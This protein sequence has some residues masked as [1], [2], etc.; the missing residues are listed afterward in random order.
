MPTIS[1]IPIRLSLDDIRCAWGA[2]RVRVLSLPLANSLQQLLRQIEAN[3]WLDAAINY[4]VLEVTGSGPGRLEA[5]GAV[6]DSALLAR[7]L[8]QA[9][10]LVFGVCTLGEG[11]LRHMREFFD[12]K[13]PSQAVLLDEIGTLLLY[14]LGDHFEEMM[15]QQ[16]KT[17]GLQA[18]GAF[19]PGDEG[20]D[21]NLQGTVLKL[22]GG[23][24]IGVTMQGRSILVPHKSLTAV[25]GLGRNMPAYTRAERCAR[26]HSRDRCPHRQDLAAGALA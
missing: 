13:R 20:F 14:K 3:R 17:M 4:R 18:S 1:D 12:S 21:I 16:A 25:I 19:N 2:E 5:G 10:H 23:A 8:Q 11:L 9:T 22:A 26:C 24:D 7:Y 15:C 6:L